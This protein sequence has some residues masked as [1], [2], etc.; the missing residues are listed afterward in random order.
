MT[1]EPPAP[2]P[3]PVPV[4]APAPDPTD[5]PGAHRV[6]ELIRRLGVTML[7]SGAQTAEIEGSLEDLAGDLGLEGV[8]VNVTFATIAISHTSPGRRT[9]TTII[10]LVRERTADFSRL[11]A[12]SALIRDLGA[13]RVDVPAA[14]VALESIE[15]SS[16]DDRTLLPILA[17]AVSAAA[18]AILFGGDPIDAVATFGVALV[19]Q[20]AIM[21]LVRGGIPPFFTLLL[22]TAIATVLAGVVGAIGG[23]AVQAP[24]IMT[25][26]LLRFLPGAALTGGVRDLIDG[27]IMSGSARLAEALMIGAGVA[28]G[29]TVGIFVAAGLGIDISLGTVGTRGWGPVVELVAAAIA[30]GAYALRLGVPGFALPAGAA[31][32]AA[33]WAIFAA[34]P[35]VV[36][37]TLLAATVVG[38]AARL[39]AWTRRAPAG[40]WV[41]PAILT[42]QPG[43][44]LVKALLA[45]DDVQRFAGIWD[46]LLIAFI[47]GVG[48]AAG[49]IAVTTIRR[50]R[51]RVLAPAVGAVSRRIELV[52][53]SRGG[54]DDE[55]DKPGVAGE[56]AERG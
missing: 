24:I 30:T 44:A 18:T 26:S 43:L 12:V 40:L 48:V 16:V 9:P 56:A 54:E 31:L 19:V 8:Q 2:S 3:A 17:T 47:L 13:G 11:A 4:A 10:E 15:T 35:T 42:L 39:L 29:A 50:V 34:G 53:A 21:T 14:E 45:P 51:R 52:V 38:A 32:G 33:A 20:A 22:G 41:V 5:G 7:G 25:A 36:V 49:D 55:A 37:G 28:A 23:L 46:A 27:E 1:P 6:L